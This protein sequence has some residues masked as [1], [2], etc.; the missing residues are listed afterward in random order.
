[1]THF[2]VNKADKILK[3]VVF[4]RHIVLRAFNDRTLAF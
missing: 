2:F 1:M 3:E 4:L